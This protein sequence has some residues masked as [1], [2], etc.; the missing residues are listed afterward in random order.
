[1]RKTMTLTLTLLML[2]SIL[3]SV[4]WVEL[5]D[6]MNGESDARAGPE[7]AVSAVLEPRAT[8]TDAMT[9]DTRN[10]LLAGEDTNFVIVV[11]NEGDADITEMNVEVTI[12]LE[13]T[14]NV[15]TD[16]LGNALSWT[17]SA[18]CDDAMSCPFDTF[19]AGE[20][21]GGGGYTVRDTSGGSLTWTPVVGNYEILVSVD[22]D[23]DSDESNNDYLVPVS[24]VDW[25]DI[26]ID[27]SWDSGAIAT[28]GQGPH[29][30]SMDISLNGSTDWSARNV[31]IGVSASGSGL[32]SATT[33]AGDDLTAGI[34]FNAGTFVA[35]ATTFMNSEDANNTTTGP[36]YVLDW[37]ETASLTGS[38]TGDTGCT[39]ACT[40]TI[41]ASLTSYLVYAQRC[42]VEEETSIGP[43]EDGIPGNADDDMGMMT[44][45]HF[46]DDPDN[47]FNTD[48]VNANSEAEIHG[49]ITNFNDIG[50]MDLTILQGY[51]AGGGGEPTLFAKDGDTVGVGHTVILAE[52][53]HRG[54]SLT[55][56]YDWNV[57]FTVADVDGTVVAT[58]DADECTSG[59]P[60]GMMPYTHKLLGDDGDP[61]TSGA[62]G[63]ACATHDME[64]GQ[65]RFTAEVAM[66]SGPSSGDMAGS[67]DDASAE[68][69]AFNNQPVVSLS[70]ESANSDIVV[71]DIVTF[72]A[73]A[74]DADDPDGTGLTYDW[75]RQSSDGSANDMSECD[76]TGIT[77]A[78]VVIDD[79]V[80]N[81]PVYV[82]V[83]DSYGLSS[84]TALTNV[85]VWKMDMA[86]D[87]SA[88]GAELSYELTYDLTQQFTVSITDANP[89][90][91]ETLQGTGDT[92]YDSVVA[93]DYVPSTT[94]GPENVLDQSITLQFAGDS[95]GDYSLWYQNS[96]QWA[97]LSDVVTAVDST[98][99][100]ITHD[101][102]GDAGILAQGTLAVFEGAEE[103]QPP[104][105]GIASISATPQ[106]GGS[107]VIS[108][109][110][111]GVL[112]DGDG[113]DVCIDNCDN[114]IRLDRNAT[115]YTHAG[116]THG[117]SYDITLRVSNAAGYNA[118]VG[119]TQVEADTM[120][121]PASGAG[122]MTFT[123][124]TTEVTVSW[125]TTDTSDVTA[126]KV[127]WSDTTF[128][129]NAMDL[130]T[131][132]CENT[133]DNT[134]SHNIA[135]NTGSGSHTL[136]VSVGGVDSFG[137]S[138]SA[139]A[140]N[141]MSYT[142]TATTPGG[143]D[144]I[145]VE[146]GD[147]GVP[148]WAWGAIIGIVVVAFVVGAF[149][150]SR[151]GEGDEGK[152]W[153]Y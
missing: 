90:V 33:T 140:M 117:T 7:A 70:V 11:I 126:W 13:G 151:G 44:K 18:V 45:I 121:S 120:V 125:T 61:M 137:N 130:G 74:F 12:Y 149:I 57:T 8:Y 5:D 15:A 91:G 107:I 139:D 42:Q 103:L 81:L 142:V 112:V 83:T 110:A 62:S 41:T 148:S 75:G 6:R 71:G 19:A 119:N 143:G 47:P 3:A 52:V 80:G 87:T 102:G 98:N 68:V 109:T 1:M 28:T 108:W 65:Y 14:M 135:K 29:G 150:L 30:F 84:E 37:G 113:F 94:Y 106:A 101:L 129:A 50:M 46:C 99:V 77:C 58:Y 64:D 111:S 131:V 136:F 78:A 122:A 72:I 38:V 54:S 85:H 82:T 134:A 115:T 105:A 123:D 25:F 20:Y 133:A 10:S 100:S 66:I 153:D 95:A 2:A 76:A 43:G 152:E 21:L 118:V 56:T 89:I 27:L 67:N 39:G 92:S 9:G 53:S 93:L 86:S 144:D 127:C 97:M 104:A 35:N 32:S 36:R 79:W 49:S 96:N 23:Q 138:E 24:V 132:T 59:M 31:T 124:S 16:A 60:G 114:P 116:V 40:Y 34:S 51:G 4:S 17:D 145:G 88:S 147:G 73:S 146:G 128:D 48:D 69:I 141:D 55:E 22:T 26:V 63:F